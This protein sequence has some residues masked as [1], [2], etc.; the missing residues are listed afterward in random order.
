MN[1]KEKDK[2]LLVPKDAFEEEA[3]EG[4][5]RLSREEAEEDLA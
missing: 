3:S 4:L 2:R 1:E 5:G